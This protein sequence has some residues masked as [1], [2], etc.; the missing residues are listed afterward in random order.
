MTAAAKTGPAKQPLPASSHP[1][2]GI[3]SW[4]NGLSIS[5]KVARKIHQKRGHNRMHNTFAA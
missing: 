4:K 2:S 1:A 5:C 3:N